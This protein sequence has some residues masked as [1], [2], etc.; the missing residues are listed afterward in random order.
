MMD[1]AD[2]RLLAAV[3]RDAAVSQADLVH[4]DAIRCEGQELSRRRHRPH[5]DQ[6]TGASQLRDCLQETVTIP[7][8]A[9]NWD[10]V[11]AGEARVTKAAQRS[12][13]RH[14]TGGATASLRQ[15]SGAGTRRS[16]MES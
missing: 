11:F 10:G 12:G 4:A 14:V 15:K 5:R 7:G 3:Q 6:A 16:F 2:K 1:D 9:R 8:R 13:L